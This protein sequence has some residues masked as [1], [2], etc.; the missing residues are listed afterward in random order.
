MIYIAIKMKNFFHQKNKREYFIMTLKRL[1]LLDP[2]VLIIIITFLNYKIFRIT[3]L[4]PRDFQV[5]Y[6]L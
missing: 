4:V 6:L 1:L 3:S 2:T 5:I